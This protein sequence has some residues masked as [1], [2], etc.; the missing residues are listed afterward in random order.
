MDM[1]IRK[2]IYFEFFSDLTLTANTVCSFNDYRECIFCL[3]YIIIM[4]NL[5]DY[6]IFYLR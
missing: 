6:Y 5:Y 2:K 4:N 3:T 1:G